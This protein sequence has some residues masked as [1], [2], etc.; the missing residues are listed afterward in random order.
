[1][2][3][4]KQVTSKLAEYKQKL[5]IIENGFYRGKKH[6]HIFPKEMLYS[7]LFEIY[8][9]EI[10]EYINHNGHKLHIYFNHLNSSQALAFNFFYPFIIERRMDLICKAFG[11]N[12]ALDSCAFEKVFPGKEG[13]NFDF[14]MK[15]KS[16]T[17]VFVEIKYT[18]DGFGKAKNDEKHRAKFINT[19][20]PGLVN[21][22][23][24]VYLNKEMVFKYYQFMRYVY[25]L[26]SNTVDKAI[27]IYPRG[28]RIVQKQLDFLLGNV[29]HDDY[30]NKIL[31]LLW[32]DLIERVNGLLT[33]E[34]NEKN[35]KLKT[36]L[37]MMKDKYFQ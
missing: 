34:Q 7:N 4:Q 5:D 13:T 24:P 35:I 33:A 37:I 31:P 15:F 11:F 29:I 27:F 6:C 18:E 16:G 22:I 17:G 36:H 26:Q 30:K 14:Y 12:E 20:S 28:N 32:E 21:K 1:M 2:S 3:F 19:Y 10:N 8:R 25:Y 23:N 9:E